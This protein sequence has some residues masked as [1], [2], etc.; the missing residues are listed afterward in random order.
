MAKRQTGG[1]S[2]MGKSDKTNFEY[3]H[4]VVLQEAYNGL[5]REFLDLKK[6][7]IGNEQ[8]KL[9]M[10]EQY[11]LLRQSYEDLQI[12][13]QE[14]QAKLVENLEKSYDAYNEKFMKV[15]ELEKQLDQCNKNLEEINEQN[16]NKA[17]SIQDQINQVNFQR[18]MFEEAVQ[19][20]LANVGLTLVAENDQL[21][22]KLLDHKRLQH[23]LPGY[24]NDGGPN[25]T[26]KD[27]KIA[28]L[29]QANAYL[30]QTLLSLKDFS[31][32]QQ[33]ELTR[34]NDMLQKKTEECV[35]LRKGV[36]NNSTTKD[37]KL[38]SLEQG[39]AFLQQT[40]LS[41]RE[42]SG[43]QQEELTRTNDMLQKRTEECVNLRKGSQRQRQGE[44]TISVHTKTLRSIMYGLS[45]MSEFVVGLKKTIC[46]QNSW[47]DMLVEALTEYRKSQLSKED[48][49]KAAVSDA[50]LPKNKV[51]GSNTVNRPSNSAQN[52]SNGKKKK[53]KKK[54][55]DSGHKVEDKPPDNVSGVASGNSVILTDHQT[56]HP[57]DV[58]LSGEIE[59]NEKLEEFGEFIVVHSKRR[60]AVA[61]GARI[62]NANSASGQSHAR[63][64]FLSL[65]PDGRT[66]KNRKPMSL[67]HQVQG[68]SIS[69]MDSGR[70]TWAHFNSDFA[71]QNH[72]A[73]DNDM[74]KKEQVT[75]SDEMC[76]MCNKI[77]DRS[78][79]L[80]ERR[81]HINS[82]FES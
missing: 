2:E 9:E 39:N 82:H 33:E 7:F 6:L 50:S 55:K 10:E 30:Q 31:G 11:L 4:F 20:S 56:G 59:D 34:T 37:E 57:G 24:N 79:D 13:S 53:P 43:K 74:S 3:N 19:S 35:N 16:K 17:G 8:Q 73:S 38:A 60:S 18:K 42:F 66:S 71:G 29:E 14:Q 75:V 68:M 54:T 76:P 48:A 25:S 32:K 46:D 78:C 64:P 65:Q 27:K 52:F 62:D 45:E 81:S 1:K 58:L 69:G 36:K 12:Q 28:S 21:E 40:L 22:V 26:A 63:S 61:Q 70:K 49:N 41:L 77:F 67:H 80:D 44:G 47:I 15:E 72:R 23:L 5:Q 51:L